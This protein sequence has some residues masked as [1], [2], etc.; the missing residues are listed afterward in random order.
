MR[1]RRVQL[2]GMA[3]ICAMLAAGAAAV[4]GT[5]PGQGELSSEELVYEGAPIEVAI[6]VNGEAAVQ[7][8]GGMLDAAAE[9]AQEQ[10]SAVAQ[11]KVNAPGPLGQAA[12]AEPLIGPAKDVIKS[13]T[14]V[15]VLVMEPE[16]APPGDEVVAYYHGLM[17][18]RGW[19]PMLTV[20]ADGGENIAVLLAPG[21]KGLF[22]V[23]RPDDDQLI[24]GLITTREPL[25]DLLA[26]IVRAGGSEVLPKF[27]AARARASEPSPQAE[28]TCDESEQPE[29]SEAGPQG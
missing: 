26:Q 11:G 10:V 1:I 16:Q 21:G 12:M 7:L 13:I 19:T 6:D 18:A 25:G 29:A 9:I 28:E 5:D 15:T 3:L 20:R 14:R 8:I 22:G 23:I 4:A 27:L 2:A 17:T 24:V